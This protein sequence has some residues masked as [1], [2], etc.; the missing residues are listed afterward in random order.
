MNHA[1]IA[2]LSG[3]VFGLIC[4][5]IIKKIYDCETNKDT[6]MDTNVHT[7]TDTDTDA[8]TD[9]DTDLIINRV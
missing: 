2:S 7:D 3:G 8:D 9:V 4:S 6:N 1:L 5:I